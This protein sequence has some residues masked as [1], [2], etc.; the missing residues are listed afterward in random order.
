M[1]D[2]ALLIGL[3]IAPATTEPVKASADPLEKVRCVREPVTGSL[4]DV[5]KTCHTIREWQRMRD[6]TQLDLARVQEQVL[7]HPTSG[8]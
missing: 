2:V 1:L 3:F 4:A 7:Q 5:R 8:H 6:A